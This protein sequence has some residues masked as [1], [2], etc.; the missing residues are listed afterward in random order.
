MLRDERVARHLQHAALALAWAGAADLALRQVARRGALALAGFDGGPPAAVVLALTLAALAVGLIASSRRQFRGTA[1]L[2]LAAAMAS[3]LFAQARLGA[4][5]QSDGFFYYAYLRSLAFDRDVNFLNDYQALGLNQAQHRFLLEPTATGHAQTAWSIGPALLW[6]PFFA[7]GHAV[8]STLSARGE[9]VDTL[10][11]S[12]PY[13]QSVVVANLLY[14]LLGLWFAYRFVRIHRPMHEAAAGVALTAA[15]SFVLWYLVREPTMAHAPSMAA[16]ALFLWTWAAGRNARTAR[17]WLLLGLA[18]GLMMVVRWQNAIFFLLP[19]VELLRRLRARDRRAWVNGILLAAGA[20]VTFSPQMF[21]WKAIYGSWL[22]M[23][24]AGPEMRWLDPQIADVLWSSR[25]GLFAWSP[26]FL[27]GLAGLAGLTRREPL[28][29]WSALALFGL[30]AWVNGA[31]EDW[32]GGAGFGMRRFDSL[33]PF[34]AL[35]VAAA[36]SYATGAFRRNPQWIAGGAL[37]ALVL[38]NLSL[39]AVANSGAYR[40]GQPVSFGEA[41]AGQAKVLHRW[42]GHPFSY[43]ANLL[44][45]LRNGVAPWRYDL[46]RPYRFLGDPRRPYGRVDVGSGDEWLLGD[47]WHGAEADGATTFRWAPSRASVLIPLDH[48]APLTV[49][50]RLHAFAYPGAAPQHVTVTINGRAHGPLP[51]S[52]GWETIEL[53]T[54]GDVWREGINRLRLEFAWARSPAEAG[55]GGDGRPLAAAVDYVRVSEK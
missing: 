38:W 46:L 42:F 19:A 34:T 35:G 39:M 47:G 22:V 11:T 6:S 25:N 12:Y 28:V 32:W 45:G 1:A 3:G 16:V 17:G 20:L 55:L 21:A 51:V 4:R 48:A 29:A 44:Y 33:V 2:I 9:A 23:S 31:V 5:L 52:G 26:I 18:G 27:V 36:L 10:G 37:A 53:T 54:G 50:V 41:G 43:P 7:A 14:G 15:G 24:P 13:R 49:Q 40:L 8:A 30:T